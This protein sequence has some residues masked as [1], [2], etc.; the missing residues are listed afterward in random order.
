M[1]AWSNDS[2][3]R[4]SRFHGFVLAACLIENG[5]KGTLT[6]GCHAWTLNEADS[7]PFFRQALDSGIIFFDRANVYSRG[8]SEEV[9]GRFLKNNTQHDATV[10]ATKVHGV[11]RDGPNGS[12][13]SRK[14]MLNEIDNSLRRLQ[15]DYVD[16]SRFIAGITRHLYRRLWRYIGDS[17]G[18]A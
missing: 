9:L 7:Q 3:K 14:A 4:A 17:G 6:P 16:L 15:T 10:I 12:G 11:M 18:A 5:Q 2:A 13:L 1:E 8:A